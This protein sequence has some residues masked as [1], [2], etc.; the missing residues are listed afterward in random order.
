MS[1]GKLLERLV[2]ASGRFALLTGGARDLPPH[3]RTLQ[4]T[5]AWSYELLEPEQKALFA[6]LAVFSGSFSL[7]A[8]DEVCSLPT[9]PGLDILEGVTQ[10]VNKSLLRHEESGGEVRFLM[11][12]TL[13]EYGLERL[14]E[15][16]E[17]L[18]LRHRHAAYYEALVARA[19]PEL[20]RAEQA[21]WLDRLEREHDNLRAAL[22]RYLEAAQAEEV[23]S[24]N[25][26]LWRY[27]WVRGQPSE[28]QG[29]LERALALGE[30]L[31][32]ETRAR[33]LATLAF[34]LFLRGDLQRASALLEESLELSASMALDLKVFAHV[35]YGNVALG[36]GDDSLAR[37][38]LAEALALSRAAQQDDWSGAALDGMALVE[39][40][41]GNF[42]TAA[43][44]LEEAEVMLRACE[45]F[46]YLMQNLNIQ[47]LMR[48]LERD[49][50]LAEGAFRESLALAHRL[51]NTFA[52]MHALLGLAMGAV[53]S[54]QGEKA[55]RL[56]GAAEALRE[57]RGIR[58]LQAQ[59]IRLL[60]DYHVAALRGQL[61]EATFAREW[62]LGRR[63]SLDEAVA[64]ALGPMTPFSARPD[65]ELEAQRR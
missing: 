58:H 46:I 50:A 14:K 62:A 36:R 9:S 41:A 37:H 45:D 42:P 32:E 38:Q 60:Y 5:I 55:A 49:Y 17:E 53:A 51:K 44:H 2:R 52:L 40:R 18:A 20:V 24:I 7:E 47:G 35:L 48:L 12:E 10:L 1:L 33:G 30:N 22:E 4:S 23:I 29:W 21:L 59:G 15:T 11:L 19:A 64:L 31:S 57:S 54:H 16:G 3:Q 43:A 39:L 28:G 63:L 27:W 56:F 61:D 25:W 8:A 26:A 13:R 34:T 6:R 65:A